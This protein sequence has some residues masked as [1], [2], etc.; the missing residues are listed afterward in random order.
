MN[1]PVRGEN[2]EPLD[3]NETTNKYFP[4]TH[5]GDYIW[6]DLSENATDLSSNLLRFSINEN[7]YE[8]IDIFKPYFNSTTTV[9]KESIYT[10]IHPETD[11][12]FNFLIGSVT[13]VNDP[14]NNIVVETNV[15]QIDVFGDTYDF[16]LNTQNGK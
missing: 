6:F 15:Q 12:T 11:G 7:N 8:K 1:H 9:D 5:P 2:T 10:Y 3:K 14:V 13:Y 16:Y 4:L